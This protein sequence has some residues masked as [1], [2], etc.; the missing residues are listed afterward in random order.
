MMFGD[1]DVQ[2]LVTIEEGDT[3]R[4]LTN[5]DL[6]P[7]SVAEMSATRDRIAASMWHNYIRNV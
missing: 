4:P 5:I 6:S 3:S 1:F 2:D 7:A